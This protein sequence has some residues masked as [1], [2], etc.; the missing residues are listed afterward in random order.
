VSGAVLGLDDGVLAV[1]MA[2]DLLEALQA[3]G[4]S[5]AVARAA[6]GMIWV[7]LDLGNERGPI[8][9]AITPRPGPNT[10][11]QN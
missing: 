10:S 8:E 5:G 1:V 7:L 6:W 11:R 9:A 4:T 3:G 2:I